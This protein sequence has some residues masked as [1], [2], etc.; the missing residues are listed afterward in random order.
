[1]PDYLRRAL[2]TFFQALLGSLLTSGVLSAASTDG[3]VDWSAAQKAAVAALA[4]GI[5]AAF[6]LA[7]NVLEDHTTMPA[8]LKAP[9]SEGE[10][11]VPEPPPVPAKPVR[12]PR[13]RVVRDDGQ[14]L[15]YVL[16]V[17]ILIVL[18]VRLL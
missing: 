1:M 15:V 5:I 16:L 14:S 9:A 12:K 2:R 13:K 4:A 17:V 10:N 8:L 18:L 11:P 6:T 3:V 7:Q